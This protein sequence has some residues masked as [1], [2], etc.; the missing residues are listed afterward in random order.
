[1]PNIEV[2]R[3]KSI[4]GAHCNWT[5]DGNARDIA[6]EE[7]REYR[8]GNFCMTEEAFAA[9]QKFIE[10]ACELTKGCDVKK[11]KLLQKRFLDGL[12]Y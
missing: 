2:C 1:V 11:L 8:V 5:V 10:Q 12:N 9:N 4:L 3:D 6:W 7:W